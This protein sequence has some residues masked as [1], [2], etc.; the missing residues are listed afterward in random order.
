M[1]TNRICLGG[2]TPVLKKFEE[3]VERLTGQKA[4]NIRRQS[5]SEIRRGTEGRHGR[6]MRFI[7]M[8]PFIGRGNVMRDRMVSH[9]RVEKMLDEALR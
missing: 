7:S 3:D 5:L 2:D 8:F 6:T 1:K 4:E 9:D